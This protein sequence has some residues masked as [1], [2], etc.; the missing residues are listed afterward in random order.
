MMSTI[1]MATAMRI[2]T[3]NAAG[4]DADLIGRA[5]GVA[6]AREVAEADRAANEGG[7]TAAPLLVRATAAGGGAHQTGADVSGALVE[8]SDVLGVLVV[9]DDLLT[10]GHGDLRGCSRE[11]K[12]GVRE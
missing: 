6:G 7:G 11:K 9:V 3:R 4:D 2:L 1:V 8:A 12:R 5:V 10:V